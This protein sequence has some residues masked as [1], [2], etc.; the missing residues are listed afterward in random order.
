[1]ATLTLSLHRGAEQLQDMNI[2]LAALAVIV[3]LAEI[4]MQ[5]GVY[6]VEKAVG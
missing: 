6:V 2:Y 4:V 5:M 3:F 1:M